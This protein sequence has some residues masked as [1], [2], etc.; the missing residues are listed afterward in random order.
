MPGPYVG[1][2]G[3]DTGR[4]PSANVFQ[5]IDIVGIQAGHVGG[6]FAGDDFEHGIPATGNKYTLVEADGSIAGLTTRGGVVRMTTGGTDNDECYIG[7]GV[8]EFI[9]GNINAGQ[10]RM[11]FETRV[12]FQETADQGVL[13]GLGEEALAAADAI[14]DAAATFVDKDFVG[15]RIESADPDGLDAIHRTA[16]GGGEIVHK[17]LAQVIVADTWYKLG[18]VFIDPNIFWLVNG[19]VIDKT[20]V[21]ESATDFP[22]G[23]GLHVMWGIKTGEGTTKRLDID[24]WRFAQLDPP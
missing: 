7:G 15:F 14:I 22:D 16:S 1:Y 10:G 24:W 4:S 21:K 8:D 17:E 23:E 13:I 19:V 11:G 12:K 20:G 5:G 6:V 9:L 18:L 3:A 2:A